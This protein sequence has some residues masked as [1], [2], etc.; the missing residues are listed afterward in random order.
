MFRVF[1]CGIGFILIISEDVLEEIKNLI[2]AL[3]EKC[4]VIG[5]IDK[6]DEKEKQVVFV[7][8]E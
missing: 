3:G 6:R 8:K 1:N 4:Y 7:E 2:F 5:Y